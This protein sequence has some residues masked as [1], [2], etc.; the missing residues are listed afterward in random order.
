MQDLLDETLGSGELGSHQEFASE[1]G[2]TDCLGEE[3]S[4]SFCGSEVHIYEL[5]Q[6]NLAKKFQ[7]ENRCSPSRI[8]RYTK[9]NIKITLYKDKRQSI[10]GR[11]RQA[12]Q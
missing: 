8:S 5:D 6:Q 9:Q 11:G 1:A 2:K 3:G 4:L 10:L 12:D 7:Q